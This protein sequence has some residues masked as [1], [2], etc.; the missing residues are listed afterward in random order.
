[1]VIRLSVGDFTVCGRRERAAPPLRGAKRIDNLRF[2]ILSEL[3]L[4]PYLSARRR[5]ETGN[6]FEIGERQSGYSCVCFAKCS[7]FTDSLLLHI[8]VTLGAVRCLQTHDLCG[9][10]IPQGTFSCPSGN[11]PCAAPS[12]EQPTCVAEMYLTLQIGWER[13]GR[14]NPLPFLYSLSSLIA[15]VSS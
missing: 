4:S 8:W 15:A 11:S 3:Q 10:V 7:Q 13:H 6:R 1:M 5:P 12:V 9:T 14:K 2:S